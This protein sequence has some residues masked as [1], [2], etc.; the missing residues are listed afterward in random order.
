LFIDGSAVVLSA[1]RFHDQARAEMH[2]IDDITADWL[3]TPEFLA[4]QAMRPQVSP[5]RGFA[6]G[7]VLSQVLD[8]RGWRNGPPLPRGERGYSS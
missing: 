8:E 4:I 5:Q 3:L 7:H 2:E 1:I 6:V